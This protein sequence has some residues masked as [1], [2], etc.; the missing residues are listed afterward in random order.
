MVIE[1]ETDEEDSNASSS[2]QDGD[3]LGLLDEDDNS[4]N[5]SDNDV[6]LGEN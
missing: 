1:A 2:V 6:G 3:S 5:Q 4:S